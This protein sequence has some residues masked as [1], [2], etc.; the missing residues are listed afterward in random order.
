MLNIFLDT[1]IYL[2]FYRFTNEDLI[3][4]ESLIILINDTDDIKLYITQQIKDE[5]YRNRDSQINELFTIL[6]GI[7]NGWLNL[8]TFSKKYWEY[9]K[10]KEAH[11][12][13]L[14]AKKNLELKFNEDTNNFALPPDKVIEELFNIAILISNKPDITSESRIRMD[15]WNP[16][17]KKGS[18]WDAINWISLLTFLPDQEDLYFVWV[19]GDFKSILDKNK[20][21]SFLKKEW[22]EKKKSSIFYYDTISLFLKE[23]FPNLWE[24]DEYV[25]DRQ[26]DKLLTSWSFNR[27]RQILASLERIQN[28]SDTQI[29]RIIENSLNN[30][31]IYNAHWYSPELV[32][33]VLERIV[34]WKHNI[35]NPE[36]YDKFCDTFSIKREIY[37]YLNSEWRYE[38]VP[39]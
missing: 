23:K 26:V 10:L 34:S 6:N 16:P 4:L 37:Y 12:N 30:S 39:F 27:S 8:P 38:E 20:I 18:L 28:F 21:N 33:A 9:D 36:H 22:E 15:L 13:F 1:N 25:K 3:K 5:F 29:N 35:I 2:W 24:L 17:G 32:W 19:D 11:K 31:Q 7:W 14:S